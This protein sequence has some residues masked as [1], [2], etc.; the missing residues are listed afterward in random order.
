MSLFVKILRKPHIY[1][2]GI[3]PLLL[4][5]AF[6]NIDS[7]FSIPLLGNYTNI[8]HKEMYLFYTIYFLMIGMNYFSLYWAEKPSK[9]ILTA[10]HLILQTIS[11]ILLI[12][13]MQ[14]GYENLNTSSLSNINSNT[15]W[16]FTSIVLF[17]L[18]AF[19]HIINFFSSLLSKAS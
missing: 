15:Q 6:L 14:N 9:K 16:F 5:L 8:G 11:L 7:Y 3:S 10:I 2:F 18:A 19:I 12:I 4:I 17:L 13:Y 1:F